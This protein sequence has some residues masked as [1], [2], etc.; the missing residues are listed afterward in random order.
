MIVELVE[1][2]LI[3]SVGNKKNVNE[4]GRDRVRLR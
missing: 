4:G 2:M 1:A 3:M